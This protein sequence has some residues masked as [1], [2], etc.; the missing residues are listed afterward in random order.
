MENINKYQP[1][2][3]HSPDAKRMKVK[4]LK[5]EFY[6]L[7]KDCGNFSKNGNVWVFE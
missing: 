6:E 7:V 5:V 1:I 2:N 4:Y 3:P